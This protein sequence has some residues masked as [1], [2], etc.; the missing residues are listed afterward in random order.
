MLLSSQLKRPEQFSY[1]NFLKCLHYVKKHDFT[2]SFSWRHQLGNNIWDTSYYS[3]SSQLWL[4]RG[5]PLSSGYPSIIT[6]LA[7]CKF[8]SG[9]VVHVN[10]MFGPCFTVCHRIST[11]VY[12]LSGTPCVAYVYV[13]LGSIIISRL[14][15]LTLS[16]PSHCPT[17]SRCFP[18]CVKDFKSV[19]PC[20]VVIENFFLRTEPALGCSGSP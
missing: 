6:S 1:F 13:F 9:P 18:F 14:Y 20:W 15:K 10:F 17:K 16:D 11:A 3:S 12:K 8:L 19:R 7:T 2:W 4:H 5:T